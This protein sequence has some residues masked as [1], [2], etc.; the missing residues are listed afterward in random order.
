MEPWRWSPLI[1]NSYCHMHTA[2]VLFF[3]L[4]CVL[5][6]S[7][8]SSENLTLCPGFQNLCG[9]SVLGTGWETRETGPFPGTATGALRSP[10]GSA[11]TWR[12]WGTTQ[13]HTQIHICCALIDYLMRLMCF[14]SEHRSR[15]LSVSGLNTKSLS[16]WWGSSSLPPCCRLRNQSQLSMRGHNW[17]CELSITL[18]AIYCINDLVCLEGRWT[19]NPSL[20][21]ILN[22]L[23]FP[24]FT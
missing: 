17:K 8:I 18:T 11:T 16:L 7:Q 6:G 12:R 5:F 19:I 13:Q 1:D 14:R 21:Y 9:K 15:C 4:R 24:P 2:K 10:C 3:N 23:N 20:F 22:S